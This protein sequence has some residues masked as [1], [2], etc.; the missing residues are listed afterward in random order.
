VT[1]HI[2]KKLLDFF[3]EDMLRLF[4]FERFLFDRVIPRD[5]EALSAPKDDCHEN[6]DLERQFGPA[7]D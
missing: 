3:D 6:R 7:A 4:D 2:P 1:K 5:R